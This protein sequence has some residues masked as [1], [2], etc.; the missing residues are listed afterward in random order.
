M[1]PPLVP[2]IAVGDWYHFIG[3]WWHFICL[4]PPYSKLF[5]FAQYAVLVFD[6]MFHSSLLLCPGFVSIFISCVGILLMDMFPLFS[7][8]RDRHFWEDENLDAWQTWCR[9]ISLEVIIFWCEN[10]KIFRFV[11][12]YFSFKIL[13]PYN[14]NW[15]F[16][17]YIRDFSNH[18]I[19]C[20]LLKF[21]QGMVNILRK[22][23]YIGLITQRILHI[24][25]GW[26][27]VLYSIAWHPLIS[28][29]IYCHNTS[30]ICTWFSI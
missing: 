6:Q 9:E 10:C 4:P 8:D 18:F 23:W 16:R 28:W 24:I 17:L 19:S 20:Q 5:L 11:H 3:M 7:F 13:Y 22:M 21:S 14:F 26:K 12:C 25:W 2:D 15:I 30:I 29:R 1:C 27:V